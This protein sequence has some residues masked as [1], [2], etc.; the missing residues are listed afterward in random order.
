MAPQS[1]EELSR[2]NLLE[3]L[4]RIGN[5]VMDMMRKPGWK[6]WLECL[7]DLKTQ[8]M[9][10]LLKAKDAM[11]IVRVQGGLRMLDFV[12]NRANDFVNEAEQAT[13]E[14]DMLKE[15]KNG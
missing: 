4:V 1:G 2:R 12:A 14:L 6:H 13:K 11:D 5:E 15:G 3:D 8:E 7:E 10:K 9:E